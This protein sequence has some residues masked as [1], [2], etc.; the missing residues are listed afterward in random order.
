MDSSGENDMEK[1]SG[2]RKTE[3]VLKLI[4]TALL[5]ARPFCPVKTDRNS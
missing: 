2:K 5:A 1:T 4:A 3:T